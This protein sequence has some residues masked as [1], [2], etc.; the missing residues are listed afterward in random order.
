MRR[1]PPRSTRV[2][3]SAASDVYKRQVQRHAVVAL[4][5]DLGAELAQ[6]LHQV[7]GER[8]VVVDH[9]D[10]GRRDD[11]L[12]RGWVEVDGHGHCENSSW[13]SSMARRSAAALFCVSSYSRAG[14]LS[15]TMPAPACTWATPSASV[16]RTLETMWMTC[17]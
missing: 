6:V 11:R 4:H 17:E 7:V 10:P 8:V 15:A 14:S 1:R 5:G 12:A 2:R 9:E 3:S 16:P 13:A